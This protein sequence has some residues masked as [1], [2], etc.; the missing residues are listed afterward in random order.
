[1]NSLKGGIIDEKLEREVNIDENQCR[2]EK[3]TISS[4]YEEM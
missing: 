1:M 4:K 2:K 3:S